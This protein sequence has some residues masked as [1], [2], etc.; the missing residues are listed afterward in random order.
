MATFAVLSQ[1]PDPQLRAAVE[2]EYPDRYFHWSLTVSFVRASG[3]A[4]NV[5]KALGIK[6]RQ[7][8]GS[9]SGTLDDAAVILLGPSYWGWSKAEGWEWLKSAFEAAD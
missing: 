1:S 4:A 3:T 8:D 7:T 6:T 9:I 5:S 2:R